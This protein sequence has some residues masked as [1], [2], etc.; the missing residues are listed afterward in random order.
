M[1]EKIINH[2]WAGWKIE[3]LIGHGS[4]GS[5][6]EIRRNLLDS[7]EKAAMKVISIPRNSQEIDELRADG[8]DDGSITEL[9][10]DHL[11][12]LIFEYSAMRK[13]K[14][15]S[16]IV[17]CDDVHYVQH[18]DGIGWDVFIKM[19]LLT[20]LVQAL[21]TKIPESTVVKIARDMC[22]ALEVCKNNNIVHRDIKPQNIFVSEE[23]VY[24][25]GDFGVAK[26][27]EG[28]SCGTKIGTFKYMA[29]EVYN[30]QEYG[31]AADIYSLGLVLYWLL[32]ECRLPFLPIQ[33]K[34]LTADQDMEARTRRLRGEKLPPPAHGS[35]ELVKIVLKACAYEIK[36]RYSSAQEMREALEALECSSKNLV[37][38]ENMVLSEEAEEEDRTIGREFGN[39]I[40]PKTKASSKIVKIIKKC[41]YLLVSIYF[42]LLFLPICETVIAQILYLILYGF[43]GVRY[44]LCGMEQ[45]NQDAE[46]RRTKKQLKNAVFTILTFVVGTIFL[47]TLDSA[48]GE[49]NSGWLMNAL[50]LGSITAVFFVLSAYENNQRAKKSVFL[51]SSIFSVLNFIFALYDTL[52]MCIEYLRYT[53]RFFAAILSYVLPSSVGQVLLYGS[54]S[55]MLLVLAFTPEDQAFIL[56]KNKG[57]KKTV[58]ITICH[59]VLAF[60]LIIMWISFWNY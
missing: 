38:T 29:P 7:T 11:K 30:N 57:L 33:P 32:N 13:L 54:V 28:T 18:S 41:V 17:N 42:I 55:A 36:D 9:Y 53:S 2:P 31:S 6:Y 56:G 8:Y 52:T 49:Y 47:L 1:H 4:Y 48:L 3:K 34:T 37:S 39:N 50:F 12:G 44:I 20:P 25:L 23:G 40:N 58:F 51:V 60:G 46:E 43:L 19:E 21:P 45:K 35:K 5:V 24:K 27:M 26:V 59:V 16:N 15:C 22:T 10:K 14:D